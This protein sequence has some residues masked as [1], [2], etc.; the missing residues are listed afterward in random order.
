VQRTRRAVGAPGDARE[1]WKILRA[2]S[3]VLGVRLP[4]DTTAQIRER[5][6]LC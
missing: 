1:D 6:V 5:C 2:L 3:D 4:Y